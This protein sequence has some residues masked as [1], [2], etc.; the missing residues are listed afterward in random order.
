MARCVFGAQAIC[1]DA[2]TASVRMILVVI[3]GSDSYEPEPKV[4]AKLL[5]GRTV[6]VTTYAPKCGI[7][8]WNRLSVKTWTCNFRML[9]Y[10]AAWHAPC[11]N[12]GLRQ[13]E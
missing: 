2:P 7:T 8:H 10:V 1:C 9:N 11:S 3:F 13:Y 4:I 12:A 5:D 6:C